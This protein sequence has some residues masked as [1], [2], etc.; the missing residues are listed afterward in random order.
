VP[1]RRTNLA[2]FGALTIAFVTGVLAYGLGTGWN[3]WAV[4]VHG[5]AGLA[6]VILTPWKSIVARRG[7]ERPRRS[8][9]TAS[10]V[11]SVLV[12]VS[13]VAG[14]LH[15]SGLA[16]DLGPVSA[17][18]VHVGAALLAL[19]LALWHVVVRRVR[20]QRSDL[21]R[22]QLLRAA[23]L[24]AGGGALF[25]GLEGVLRVTSL[26]GADRRFSGSHEEGSFAPDDMPVTQW[27]D[28]SVPAINVDEWRLRID[29]RVLS[30]EEI[31]VFDDEVEAVLDCTGGWWARQNW[32]GVRLD[33]IV[34]P[35]PEDRSIAVTSATG[36][37]RRLPLSDLPHLL[38][39]TR[40]GGRALSA[41]HGFPARLVAPGRRGF[42]WIKWV[43][44]I[45]TSPRPWW[46][47]WP[48][49]PT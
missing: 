35:R 6:I 16:A 39:A 26:P 13:I 3:R 9:K 21:Q 44:K 46:F 22:R 27:L 14:V 15:S 11:F 12:V 2:L 10:L 8:G 24:V 1:G 41:G 28:D 19:P 32:I 33:R 37:R 7:L 31:L 30:Y 42:W 43:T 29:E 20:V 5:V 47:Q 49:P 38:L 48:F 34:E 4:I 36:Y 45:E 23:G 18:Q 17:M 25:V 40:V